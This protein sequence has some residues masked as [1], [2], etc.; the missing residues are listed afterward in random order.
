MTSNRAAQKCGRY[1]SERARE[2]IEWQCLNTSLTDS[3]SRILA[4]ELCQL[5]S[6]DQT[7][8]QRTDME[9]SKMM[10]VSKRS[11]AT[12]VNRL[13]E[14]GEW[15]VKSVPSIGRTYTPLF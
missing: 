9:M 15:D 3:A 2:L 11:I 12:Y 14:S 8:I 5:F 1:T 10:N 4:L 7:S 13:V 6:D